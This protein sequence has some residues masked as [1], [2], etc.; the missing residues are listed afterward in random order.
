MRW[1]RYATVGI[2]GVVAGAISSVAFAFACLQA[3]QLI[4]DSDSAGWLLVFT[5]P[6]WLGLVLGAGVFVGIISAMF[7]HKKLLAATAPVRR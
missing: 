2:A 4:Y 3:M 1:L 6:V 7:V 5:W